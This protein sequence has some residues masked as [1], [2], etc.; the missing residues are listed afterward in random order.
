VNDTKTHYTNMYMY[1]TTR[2]ELRINKP[3]L[4]WIQIV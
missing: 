1:S 2:L 3:G 4:C